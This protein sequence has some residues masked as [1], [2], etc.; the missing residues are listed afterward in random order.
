MVQ[1]RDVVPV[2]AKV[3][4]DFAY[5]NDLVFNKILVSNLHIDRHNHYAPINRTFAGGVYDI[6]SESISSYDYSVIDIHAEETGTKFPPKSKFLMDQ[7]SCMSEAKWLDKVT[8]KRWCF[9]KMMEAAETLELRGSFKHP[10]ITNALAF[11][12]GAPDNCSV[13]F[14]RA[15]LARDLHWTRDTYLC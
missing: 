2:R 14:V 4:T 8:G 7:Y 11:P 3:F 12:S 5:G 1:R 9:Y 10:L 15:V 13:P 6:R